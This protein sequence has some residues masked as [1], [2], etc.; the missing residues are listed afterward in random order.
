MQQTP[1]L[2][3]WMAAF[4]VMPIRYPTVY[5]M[6]PQKKRDRTQ[7]CGIQMG[8]GGSIWRTA[9][10]PGWTAG[11]YYMYKSIGHD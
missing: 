3:Y 5:W 6:F 8:K 9:F 11:P 7:S 10:W 2:A 1:A 4:L